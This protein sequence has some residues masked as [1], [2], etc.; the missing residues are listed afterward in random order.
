MERARFLSSGNAYGKI[1]NIFSKEVFII[2]TSVPTWLAMQV[3][4]VE[5]RNPP[6]KLV[7]ALKAF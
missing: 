6:E 7:V 4:C 3:P 1:I 2:E 5:L